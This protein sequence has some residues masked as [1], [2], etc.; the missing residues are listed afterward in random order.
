MKLFITNKKELD[1]MF[2]EDGNNRY[3]TSKE[4]HKEAFKEL[5]LSINTKSSIPLCLTP[6]YKDLGYVLLDFVNKKEDVY[7]YEFSTTAS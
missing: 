2:P 3:K 7:F 1:S 6:S 4:I 5:E